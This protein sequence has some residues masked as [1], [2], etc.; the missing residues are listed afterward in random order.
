MSLT[1]GTA[2]AVDLVV[3]SDDANPIKVQVKTLRTSNCYLLKVTDV[4]PDIVYVFVLLHRIGEQVEFFVVS[5]RTLIEKETQIWGKSGGKV[6]M[7]GITM[8]GIK[9]YKNNWQAFRQRA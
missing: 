8:G 4:D 9:P 5:G 3:F 6:T 2:K 7:A 1:F